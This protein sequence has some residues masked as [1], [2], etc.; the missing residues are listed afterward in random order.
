MEIWLAFP[1]DGDEVIETVAVEQVGSHRYRL[2][3]APLFLEDIAHHDVIHAS[4]RTDGTFEFRGIIERSG[5]SRHDYLLN[6]AQI[7]ALTDCRRGEGGRVFRTGYG[8]PAADPSATRHSNRHHRGN[9]CATNSQAWQCRPQACGLTA[10]V[11][12]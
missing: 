5:W 9:R 11:P 3:A 7:E 10:A 4:P 6:E 2:E 1:V 12:G 8:R